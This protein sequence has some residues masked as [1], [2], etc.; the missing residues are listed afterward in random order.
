[1]D[2]AGAEPFEYH[3]GL[4]LQMPYFNGDIHKH[5]FECHIRHGHTIENVTA[6]RAAEQIAALIPQYLAGFIAKAD[7]AINKTEL[8]LA[9][10]GSPQERSDITGWLM[11]RVAKLRL[12][13]Q[14]ALSTC[15]VDFDAEV[16]NGLEKPIGP[17]DF[18][19]HGRQVV[20][21]IQ[22]CVGLRIDQGLGMCCVKSCHFSEVSRLGCLKECQDLMTKH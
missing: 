22:N 7:E 11:Q 6:G 16:K 19:Q 4:K 8:K 13:N 17:E 12:S 2:L 21:L 10:F 9:A 5:A 18:E 14:Q 3:L 15:E 1:M 20:E